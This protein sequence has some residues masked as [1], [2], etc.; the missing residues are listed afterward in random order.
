MVLDRGNQSL[1]EG[2]VKMN[3]RNWVKNVELV[4]DT[5]GILETFLGVSD[6]DRNL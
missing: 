5:M 3:T 6:S 2:S 4:E 1:Q